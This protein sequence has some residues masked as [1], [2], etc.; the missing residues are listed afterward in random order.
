MRKT[1]K[2]LLLTSM[3]ILPCAAWADAQICD[4]PSAG[5]TVS[6][7]PDLYSANGKLDLAFNYV[8]SV[9]AENRT[10]FCFVTP[11]GLESPTLHVKPGDMLN[12]ELTNT[13]PKSKAEDLEPMAEDS[14]ACDGTKMTGN[15]VNMH[16]HGLNIAPTCHSDE[17]VHTLVNGGHKFSY[18]IQIPSDE[19]PGM[20]WYHPHVHGV[21][22]PTVL[23]GASGAIEVEGIENQQPAVANLPSRI[24]IVR[25]PIIPADAA[26]GQ[27]ARSPTKGKVP[28][29][30]I[31]LN[32]VPVEY[33]ANKPGVL[34]MTP[35]QK[36]FWR[37]V[38]ASADT[39]ADL[40]V[41]YDGVTQPLQMVALDGVVNGSQDGTRRG[42]LFPATDAFIPMAGRAEFI[43]PALPA[44]VKHATIETL[45]ID[46]GPAGDVDTHR[47]LAV[48]KPA[49]QA[50]AGLPVMP[51][52]SAAPGPQRFEGLDTAKVTAHRKLYFYEIFPDPMDP[53]DGLFY[54]VVDGQTPQLYDPSAPPAITTTQGAVEDWTIENHTK[55][56]HEFHIHQIHFQVRAIDR[57]QLPPNKR[58]F[59]DTFQV[60]YWTGHGHYPSV[61]LRM[62]FRGATVGDFVYHCHIL[63][64]EDLGM[65]A[66]IRVNAAA[67]ASP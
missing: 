29:W 37:V 40:V 49:T 45:R 50:A 36:E 14:Q 54:V 55:E 19:P 41:K 5:A 3:A 38:N 22:G 1:N 43:V 58:E 17:V 51:M 24:L 26:R 30:D 32:Y 67:K 63:D 4:R 12:I 21:A 39:I 33:P 10:L 16:F 27:S 25:D 46:T 57:V 34:M 35:G 65:M 15:D 52:P 28:F 64:H 23:G 60:P 59:R 6:P 61:T 8:T 11:D 31:S 18:H 42:K 2:L 48:I 53:D 66:I 56:V 47:V 20:Y 62:D 44:N 13:L 9:D 7:P